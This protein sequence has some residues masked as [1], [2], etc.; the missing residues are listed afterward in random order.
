MKTIVQRA[1]IAA[2]WLVFALP[3]SAQDPTEPRREAIGKWMET[4]RLI[5]VERQDWRL[6]R[7]SMT[8][9]AGA[10]RHDL[11]AWREKTVQTEK[12]IAAADSELSEM[13]ARRDQLQGAL[14]RVAAAVT[15]LEQDV[16]GLLARAPEPLRDRVDPLSRRMPE[17][18][19]DSRMAVA[20]RAG[21]VIGILNEMDKFAREIAVTSEVR[22]LDDGT[23]AEVTAFYLGF[24]QAYYCNEQRGLAGLGRPGANGWVWTPRNELA[25][26]VAAAVA[27]YRNEKPAVYIPL[28]AGPK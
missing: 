1:G 8:E 20:E 27:V 16:R 28:P 13:T 12:E 14:N 6:A 7:E 19:G 5:S 21:N 18:P 25:P 24:G 3:A 11:E 4:R 26:A 22:E 15:S 9:R 10:L 2:A 17:N 23:R